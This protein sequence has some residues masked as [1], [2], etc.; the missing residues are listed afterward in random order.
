MPSDLPTRKVTPAGSSPRELPARELPAKRSAARRPDPRPMRIVY[1]AASVAALSALTVGLSHPTPPPADQT[2]VAFDTTSGA[3]PTDMV[4]QAP[5]I[6][7]QHVINYVHLLPGQTPPPGA[8]VI[9]PDAPAPRI[10]V[11]TVPGAVIHKAAPVTNTS[12]PKP[13]VRTRQSGTP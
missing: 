12:Q 9:A 3:P 8:T 2:E 7:V 6:E 5:P 10:V 1:G 11:T 13:R 4:V